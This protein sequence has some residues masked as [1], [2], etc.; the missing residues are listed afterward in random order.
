[1]TVSQDNKSNA[2]ED[3]RESK[4]EEVIFPVSSAEREVPKRSELSFAADKPVKPA[5]STPEPRGENIRRLRD[6]WADQAPIGVKPLR[7]PSVLSPEPSAG[8][9]SWVK[10]T[11]HALPG[12]AV[13][14]AATSPPSP[15]LTPPLVTRAPQPPPSPGRH[16]RIPSTGSRP[17]VME[18]AQAFSGKASE[19]EKPLVK[20]GE[21]GVGTKTSVQ[22]TNVSEQSAAKDWERTVTPAAI[23]AER[24]RSNYDKYSNFT[25]PALKEEKTPVPSPAGTLTKAAAEDVVGTQ[26]RG[27]EATHVQVFKS[28]AGA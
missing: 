4:A 17:T 23:K 3:L 16:A 13:V 27:D 8:T 24:R 15:P 28:N 19:L 11:K 2:F 10:P 20:A 7:K 21:T 22:A 26:V 5:A 14:P 6:T 18:V 1:M 12:L 25:L 9:P